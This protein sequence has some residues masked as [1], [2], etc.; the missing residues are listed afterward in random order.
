MKFNLIF[1]IWNYQLSVVINFNTIK[2]CKNKHL[3]ILFHLVN[4]QLTIKAQDLGCYPAVETGSNI[5]R[6]WNRSL[7]AIKWE[8]IDPR[9]RRVFHPGC[10][11]LSVGKEVRAR[12]REYFRSVCFWKE[13]TVAR[14]WRVRS[15]GCQWKPKKRFYVSVIE[16]RYMCAAKAGWA[17]YTG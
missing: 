10:S 14:I 12:L 11:K 2:C 1:D 3:Q 16:H 17:G 9:T 8:R 15:K 6:N 5:T 4:I 7:V 13:E